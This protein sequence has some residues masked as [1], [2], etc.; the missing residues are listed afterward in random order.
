MFYALGV[1]LA[2][3]SNDREQSNNNDPI[4]R[5]TTSKQGWQSDRIRGIKEFVAQVL[6]KE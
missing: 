2:S 3:K 4:I 1:L 5:L 6:V